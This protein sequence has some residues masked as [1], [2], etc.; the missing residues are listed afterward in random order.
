M[1]KK[2]SEEK[3]KELEK[4]L[5]EKYIGLENEFKTLRYSINELKKYIQ[6]IIKNEDEEIKYSFVVHDDKAIQIDENI[7]FSKST[8]LLEIKCFENIKYKIKDKKYIQIII[9]NEDEE[10]KYSFVVHDDKAIQ[11]DENI[12]FSKYDF[13]G[14]F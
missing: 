2:K 8:K 4:K 11:I 13:E 5:E 14:E 1:F 10:I 7:D 3:F 9:K 12:D 6:I